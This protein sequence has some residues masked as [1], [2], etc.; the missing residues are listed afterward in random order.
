METSATMLGS[1]HLDTLTSMN[2][3]V[4]TWQRQGHFTDG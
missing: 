1:E 3:L 2:N 4:F